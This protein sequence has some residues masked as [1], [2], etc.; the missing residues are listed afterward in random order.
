LISWLNVWLLGLS[1]T[2]S[3]RLTFNNLLSFQLYPD[4]EFI[5]LIARDMESFQGPLAFGHKYITGKQEINSQSIL[6]FQEAPAKVNNNCDRRTTSS[7]VN[8]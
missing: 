2:K 7:I 4:S 5:D 8:R 6:L 1:T 3:C